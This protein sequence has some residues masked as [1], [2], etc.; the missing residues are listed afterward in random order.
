MIGEPEDICLFWDAEVPGF[1][2]FP[3]RR[4]ESVNVCV[5]SRRGVGCKL[6]MF[7]VLRVAI[8]TLTPECY[9]GK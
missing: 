7:A 4:S 9:A 1:T 3:I 6:Q 5:N 2:L 8:K